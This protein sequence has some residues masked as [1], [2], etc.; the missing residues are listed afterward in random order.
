MPE[1]NEN[2]TPEGS[3]KE[4]SF[5]ELFESYMKDVK[6]DLK[7]GEQV[8]GEIIAISSDLVF[9]NTGTKA[10]GVVE[11]SELTDKDGNFSYSLGDRV[12]LYVI[13]KDESE[14]RL[15]RAMTG[16]T[17][18]HQL[19]EAYRAA[20]PVQGKV[21]E[22]CKGGF[23]V[24]V[25]GKIA[26]CPV[27]QMDVKY[28][29]NP[30][31]YV[32][33]DYEF[34]ISRIEENGRNIVVSR[35]ELLRR[36]MAEEQE[37]FLKTV[38]PGDIVEGRVTRLMPYGAFVELIPGVEG[39]VHISELSWTRVEKPQDAVSVNDTVQVKILGIRESEENTQQTRISLSIKQALGDPWQNITEK[40]AL[41]DKVEGR[42]TRCADVGAFVEISPGV[43]GLVHVSEM[44]YRKR[45]LKAHDMVSPG[46]EIN[47]MIKSID[48]EN[49]RISLSMKEAEGDPWINIE[50]RYQAGQQVA[51]TVE[52]KE[53]FGY[54]V[55]IEPGV[56]GLLPISKINSSPDASR[57]E[58]IKLDEPI[59]VKIE[60]V[61]PAERKISLGV[62]DDAEKQDFRSY[63]KSGSADSG[64][65]EL[66]EKLKEALRSG[67]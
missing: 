58:K 21:T 14:V 66:G 19:Y 62:A 63:K 28:V 65:G 54:F 15:S 45:V 30:E 55:A 20:V 8:T 13:F 61:N 25:A 24:S 17:G 41:G 46:D 27:S 40:F 64:M 56:V 57:I 47:V 7:V 42:V 38:S 4:E 26:F 12:T 29:E 23:R 18:I 37:K 67:K 48:P 52:K 33:A 60:S 3:E 49:R 32:G 1:H 51:G 10:D 9:L 2:E 59:Q 44:S 5:E 53:S 11:K 16:E 6:D 35:R 31:L 43:E 39:M 34:L 50:K 36:L 22:T